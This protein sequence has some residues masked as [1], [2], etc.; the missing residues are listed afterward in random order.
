MF[1]LEK[2]NAFNWYE[3]FL[4]LSLDKLNPYLST[5]DFPLKSKIPALTQLS[6]D[7]VEEFYNNR[8]SLYV[9]DS[10]SEATRNLFV[11]TYNKLVSELG[12]R[13]AN[14]LIEWG[15]HLQVNTRLKYSAKL[16]WETL[17]FAFDHEQNPTVT[18]L[19]SFTG[20][21]AN[22]VK[23]LVAKYKT[24][25]KFTHDIIDMLDNSPRDKWENEAYQMYN[26]IGGE[27]GESDIEVS[28][29]DV[30]ASILDF[31]IRCALFTDI[32]NLLTALDLR[33]LEAWVESQSAWEK[34]QAKPKSIY[35]KPLNLT[36]IL[37]NNSINGNT[38][39]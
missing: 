36:E 1:T 5:I 7:F 4:L 37:E 18:S 9:R 26:N 14:L 15:N 21:M 31:S 17:L 30:L 35:P 16:L 38:R 22:R 8:S 39:S 23:I 13:D 32:K 2:N 6:Q 33:L 28:P 25:L 11:E 19:P 20:D 29:L 34:M 24:Q 27:M 12:E 3:I 10:V